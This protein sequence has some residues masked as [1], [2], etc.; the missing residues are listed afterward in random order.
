M[1]KPRIILFD[2][3]TLP[4]FKEAMKVW[5]QLSNYPGLTLKATISTIICAGWKELGSTKTH[6]INAWDYS[7]WDRDM[8]DD[9][10]VVREIYKVLYN[11]DAVVTHNGK[12]FDWKFLQTRLVKHGLTPLAKTHHIDT[13]AV[14]KQNLLAFNNRL[15]TVGDLLDAGTKLSHEGWKLWVDVSNRDPKAMK[16]MTD[17]CKQDVNLLE[18]VYLKLLPFVNNIPNHNLYT[19]INVCPNCGSMQTRSMG[20]RVT[21][22]MKY[23][24]MNCKKCGTAFRLDKKE[25]NPVTF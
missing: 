20:W 12:R 13:C 15:N 17:Y 23:R 16:L 22:T 3:E 11:A 10:T 24:R 1:S 7:R 21:K 4:N 9:Y 14:A 2:L 25:L 5:P 19:D 6:C 18:K 8:N